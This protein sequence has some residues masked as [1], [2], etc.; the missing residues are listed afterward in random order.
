MRICVFNGHPDAA[1]ERL[2]SAIA[3]CYTQGAQSQGHSVV[4]LNLG[5]IEVPY[6]ETAEA[7]TQDA[8][9]QIAKVQQAIEQADHLVIVYPLWLGTLP[10]KLKALL[11]QV[12]RANFFLDT[13]GDSS[14]WP[15]KRMKGRSVRLMVTMGMPGFAYHLMFG[16]H[17]LKGLEAGIFKMAGFKPVRHSVFGA[18]GLGEKRVEQIL[19]KARQLGEKAI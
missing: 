3:D 1:P 5:E 7:F 17:S 8:S 6:L 18:I 14:R 9:P 2:C 11:E 12:G 19:A 16:A 10:A 15:V 4:R 13:G